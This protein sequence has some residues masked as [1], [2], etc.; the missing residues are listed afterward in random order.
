MPLRKTVGDRLQMLTMRL[1][2]L[3]RYTAH[4]LASEITWQADQAH[5]RLRARVFLP[6]VICRILWRNATVRLFLLQS[7]RNGLKIQGNDKV[8]HILLDPLQMLSWWR[9]W[10]N[11]REPIELPGAIQGS[12]ID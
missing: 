3:G 8:G 1:L 4:R 11:L 9:T 2:C 7:W 6:V 10:R 5:E 12:S